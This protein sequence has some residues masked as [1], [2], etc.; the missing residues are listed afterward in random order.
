MKQFCVNQEIIDFYK[1]SF[2]KIDKESPIIFEIFSICISQLVDVRKEFS[3]PDQEE[4]NQT[5]EESKQDEIEIEEEEEN[6]E[7]SKD[8]NSD[9]SNSDFTDVSEEFLDDKDYLL[10]SEYFD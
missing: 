7:S 9:E 4:M 10:M 5:D 8:M 2:T 1:H 6:D 3:E